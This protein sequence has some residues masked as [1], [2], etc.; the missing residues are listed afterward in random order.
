MLS[1]CK[2]YV[3]AYYLLCCCFSFTEKGS[4]GR[5][6]ICILV[7][8]SQTVAQVCFFTWVFPL[9][10]FAT[11]NNR[12]F[13]LNLLLFQFSSFFRFI[14][15]FA[16]TYVSWRRHV[17]KKKFFGVLFCGAVEWAWQSGVENS[18]G[19]HLTIVVCCR[20]VVVG[21]PGRAL[22]ESPLCHGSSRVTLGCDSLMK[23]Q[24]W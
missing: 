15:K 3:S 21:Q 2:V 11:L 20:V 22:S 24:S 17:K 7:F 16:H 14:S 6:A 18:W 13:K 4:L 10:P 9:P 8:G 12:A 5:A 23:K 19:K 1:K